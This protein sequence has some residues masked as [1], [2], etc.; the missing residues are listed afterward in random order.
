MGEMASETTKD[1]VEAWSYEHVA[2]GI[3]QTTPGLVGRETAAI[4]FQTN[5]DVIDREPGQILIGGVRH[6][7]LARSGRNMGRVSGDSPKRCRDG[8]ARSW[9]S[10]GNRPPGGRRD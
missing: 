10:R 1:R 8:A 7:S 9:S 6:A 5:Q 2:T 3:C 4:G